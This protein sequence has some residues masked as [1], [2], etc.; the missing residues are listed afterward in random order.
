MAAKALVKNITAADAYAP[1][2]P[3]TVTAVRNPLEPLTAYP[4]GTIVLPRQLTHDNIAREV[5]LANLAKELLTDFEGA[6]NEDNWGRR[7]TN[8]IIL[9]KLTNSEIPKER[10]AIYVGIF[11]SLI[12]GIIKSATSLR[13]SLSLHGTTLIQEAAS[14]VGSGLD[15]VFDILYRPLEK[16]CLTKPAQAHAANSA[17]IALITHLS[18]HGRTVE[19]ISIA[20]DSK[21]KSLRGYVIGWLDTLI[22]HCSKSTL[23]PHVD[24]LEK[25]LRKGLSDADGTVRDKSRGVFW[26]FSGKFKPRAD[27]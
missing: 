4:D 14:A 16:Q 7:E 5:K 2:V 19:S 9:R 23:E 10:T 6:E 12:D 27:L 8:M 25:M 20:M 11:R 17:M 21:N 3:A 13:T 22:Q 26:T 1:P 24:S 15:Q 18:F